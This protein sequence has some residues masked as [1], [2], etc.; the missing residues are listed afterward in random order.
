MPHDNGPMTPTR[1]AAQA[2]DA[3]AAD[4]DERFRDELDTKPRD[5]QLLDSLAT[6][7]SGIVLDVGCGPGHIGARIRTFGRPVVALDVSAAM[8]RTAAQQ[9]DAAIVADMAR[10]PVGT[11][12]VADLVA[13]YSVI[14]LPRPHLV[15]VLSEF[16][17][18][19]EPGG[20]ALVSA[21]EGTEDITVNDFLG[22]QVDLPATFFTLDEMVAATRDA[23]LVVI[24]AERRAPYANEGSTNRLYLELEHQ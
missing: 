19:L 3:V 24:S 13:F 18:V 17:R 8:A 5:R 21:H 10:L 14:H 22:H 16:A 4:Y 11:A 7:G 2:Y 23:G 12:T 9:L 1:R 20:H 6:R 15:G